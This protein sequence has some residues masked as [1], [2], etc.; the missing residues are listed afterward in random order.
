MLFNKEKKTKLNENEGK[1]KWN[2]G[3]IKFIVIS[4]DLHKRIHQRFYLGCY[5]QHMTFVIRT[6]R[7][8]Y[9]IDWSDDW[10]NTSEDYNKNAQKIIR[11]ALTMFEIVKKQL[12]Q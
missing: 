9:W 2:T 8:I 10:G 1:L 7:S 5:R 11:N 4:V 3:K 12:M 6:M